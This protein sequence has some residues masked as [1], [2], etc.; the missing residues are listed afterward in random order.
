MK[1]VVLGILMGLVALHVFADAACSKTLS[2]YKVVPNSTYP[3][4]IKGKKHCFFA[5]YTVN[6]VGIKESSQ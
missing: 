5:F 1:H 2:K 4:D 3:F 6:T